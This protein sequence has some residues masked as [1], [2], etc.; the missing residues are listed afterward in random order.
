MR[1]FSRVMRTLIKD[2]KLGESNE[3]AYKDLILSI[4][5]SFSVGKI[6]L[7]LVRNAKNADFLEGNCK[8]AKDRLV[9]KYAPH[10][11]LSFMNSK[12]SFIIVSWSQL[13]KIQ[14]SGS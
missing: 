5:T 11:A 10:M 9:S 7:G 12:M 3:L 8:I 14:T 1:M 4:N 2:V 13:R 6:A